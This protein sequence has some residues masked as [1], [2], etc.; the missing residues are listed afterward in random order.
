MQML[1]I[2]GKFDIQFQYLLQ[3]N[4]HLFGSPGLNL[5]TKDKTIS[6]HWHLWWDLLQWLVDD[7]DC[8]E[9]LKS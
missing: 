1:D 3:S 2:P 4:Y 9:F 7:W 6:T 5:F 8:I